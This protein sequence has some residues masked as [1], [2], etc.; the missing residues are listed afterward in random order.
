MEYANNQPNHV[1]KVRE[2]DVILIQ[3]LDEFILK[4]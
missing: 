3:P 4:F 1:S 2:L